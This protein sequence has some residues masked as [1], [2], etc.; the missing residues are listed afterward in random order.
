MSRTPP[1]PQAWA[2][3]LWGGGVV[4]MAH[5]P[6]LAEPLPFLKVAKGPLGVALSALAI[7]TFLSRAGVFGRL[8]SVRLARAPAAAL[9]F[10][11]P[12]VAFVSVGLFYTARLGVSGDE[13]HYL[14]MAQSLWRDHDLH[15]ENNAAARDWEEYTPR[16]F[17]PHY[18]APRRDGRPFP[19]H[20]PGL[21]VL[22]APAYA[23]AGRTACVVLL[24]LLAALLTVQVHALALRLTGERRAALGA[25]AV[26]V[27]PP[28][29]FYSFHLY[30][31]VPSALCLAAALFLLLGPPSVATATGAALVASLLPW[32][33]LKMIGAA[34]ALSVVA[35][36]RLRGRPLVAFLLVSGAAASAYLGYYYS[37]FGRPS[38]LGVYGGVPADLQSSSSPLRAAAGLLLDRSFGLLPHAPVYLLTLMGIRSLLAS[39]RSA[40]L[41]LL[42]VGMAVLAPVLIWRMWWGGQCPPGRFLVPLIPLLAV[43]AGA[44][45]NGAPRGLV[46][47]RGALFGIGCALALFAVRDPGQRLLLNR[48][49]R[50]TRLWAALSAEVPVERYL[51]SLTWRDPFED[52]V[53]LVWLAALLVLFGC[54]RL[55]QRRDRVDAWFRGFG[56]PLL[57]LLGIGAAVDFWARAGQPSFALAPVPGEAQAAPEPARFPPRS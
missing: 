3:L 30:T 57:L 8:P 47:W 39:R 42:A 11:V 55:A 45:L 31:E 9:L 53:A 36:V 15:L 16:A 17:A 13:P 23:F 29:F 37:V 25:W 7:M 49:N 22:L 52:R 14:L 27:G 56:L 12:A 43:G 40:A 28:L 51:P 5:V 4:V 48:A 18:G 20:S 35:I 44:A 33:H 10:L 50:P 6:P 38:P 1:S 41:A 46:R 24:G 34:A 2:A 19:A 26:A 54:D 32:L 21:A